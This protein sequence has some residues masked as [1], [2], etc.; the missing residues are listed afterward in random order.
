M[1]QDVRFIVVIVGDRQVCFRRHEQ[2]RKVLNR[3]V[4]A[5]GVGSVKAKA[6]TTPGR[7]PYLLNGAPVVAGLVHVF[8]ANG[9]RQISKSAQFVGGKFFRMEDGVSDWER[10]SKNSSD[11][12]VKRDAPKN[13]RVNGN[14]LVTQAPNSILAGPPG[15]N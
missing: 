10:Q 5:F 7:G 8:D 4:V 9:E 11:P 13:F 3:Q 15:Q 1:R 14:D 6:N 2:G 12:F